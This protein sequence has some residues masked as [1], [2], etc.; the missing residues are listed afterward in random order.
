MAECDDEFA[1]THW[2]L[3]PALRRECEPLECYCAGGQQYVRLDAEKCTNNDASERKKPK[4]RK[5]LF[6]TVYL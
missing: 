5:K 1:L 4:K 2:P 3:E 6:K